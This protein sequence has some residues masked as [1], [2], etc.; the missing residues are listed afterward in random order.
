[1][2][3]SGSGACALCER[4]GIVVVTIESIEATSSPAGRAGAVSDFL[5]DH[6]HQK[7]FGGGDVFQ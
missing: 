3:L 6:S 1:M 7:I 2:G 4:S 5:F